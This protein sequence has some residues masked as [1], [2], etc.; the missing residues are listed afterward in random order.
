MT[1][2]TWPTEQTSDW[3]K[4][5][6]DLRERIFADPQ[7]PEAVRCYGGDPNG[8]APTRRCS[9]VARVICERLDLDPAIYLG[10]VFG[11]AADAIRARS[12]VFVPRAA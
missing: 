12:L 1:T 8:V 3:L 7:F 6:E 5:Y 4:A 2:S 10:N 11:A 9:K